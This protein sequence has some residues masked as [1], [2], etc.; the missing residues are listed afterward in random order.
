MA[1]KPHIK[2][3][4]MPLMGKVAVVTGASMGIGEA[5]ARVFL[6]EGASVILSSRD[7]NRVEEARSRVG[8]LERSLGVTCD[9]RNR[10][11]IDRL[12]SL[13]VHNFGRCDIWVNNAGHGL[14]DT[15]EKLDV[16]QCR[17]L[18]ETNF[19]GAVGGM[20][21][22]IPVMRQQGGGTII[23]ISSVAGHI[24]LPGSAAYS[25]SKFALN[26]IGKAADAELQSSGV[27]VMTVCPGY[28][29]TDFA[30][31][32]VKGNNPVRIGASARRGA[33]ADEV[34]RAVLNGYLK[35]KSEV[36]VPWY[37]HAV[38][39]FYQLFPQVVSRYMAQHLRP[40]DQVIQESMAARRH[41]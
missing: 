6:K 40:A 36:V 22:A 35:Q 17:E 16:E 32:A 30:V 18:F 33:T 5:I 10:E 29:A 23:N 14:M 38:I 28:I 11:E 31:N 26:A 1:D 13:T 24:P 9:V 7:A 41:Q 20:Q 37:Y 34:A 2:D 39:K 25:A 27:R 12:L 15:V 3:Q 4:S 21:V 8:H 19:F